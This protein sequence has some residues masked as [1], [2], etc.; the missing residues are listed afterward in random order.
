VLKAYSYRR[1]VYDPARRRMREIVYYFARY[2]D[3]EKEVTWA[4]I[5]KEVAERHDWAMVAVRK[6][7]VQHGLGECPVVWIQNLP[8]SE[9]KDGESDYEGLCDMVDEI[10]MLLSATTG[11]TR[12]NVDPT[13]V[14]RMS[15]DRNDGTV[16]KGSGAAIFSEGGAEYLEIKGQAV[17]ASVTLLKELRLLALDVAQVVLADPDKLAG[18]AQSAQALRILYAPMLAKLDSLREQYG[19]VGVKRVLLGLLHGAKLITEAPEQLNP[20]T[21]LMEKPTLLLGKRAVHEETEEETPD[22]V[23]GVP[24]KVKKTETRYEERVPGTSEDITLNWNPYFA[25]TW[26]D[27]KAATEAAKLANGGL[28]VISQRTSL[29]AVQSLWGVNDVDAEMREL[30]ADSDRQLLLA[31]KAMEDANAEAMP[32]GNA[33]PGGE[34]K[35]EPKPKPAE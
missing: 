31:Q 35:P 23:L 24:R 10:N 9:D 11:G 12:A 25:P 6:A 15:P 3:E 16:Q 27:I 34:G 21:G 32:P 2:W 7:E 30:E 8:D 5:P 13:L 28:A 4:P 33:G 1:Q 26:P 14:I 17:Q 29:Q 20:E 19:E 18:A 22:E